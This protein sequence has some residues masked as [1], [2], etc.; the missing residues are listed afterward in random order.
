[1][2][3]VTILTTED[4]QVLGWTFETTENE[5]GYVLPP[6]TAIMTYAKPPMWVGVEVLRGSTYY[7]TSNRG[8]VDTLLPGDILTGMS[9]CQQTIPYDIE[10]GLWMVFNLVPES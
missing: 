2:E 3:Q 5:T 1:M 7:E 10:E 6:N 4:L 9:V 8:V